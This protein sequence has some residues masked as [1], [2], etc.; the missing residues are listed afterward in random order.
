MSGPEILFNTWTEEEKEEALKKMIEISS[1]GGHNAEMCIALGLKS[2]DTFYR[3]KREI[4]EF[5]AMCDEAR[6]YGKSFY[7]NLLLR[8]AAGLVPNFNATATMGIVNNKFAEDYKRNADGSSNTPSIGT[9][10]IVNLNSDELQYK[11]AQK[12]EVLKRYGEIY[13]VLPEPSKEE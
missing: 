2:E 7:D 9:V 5:K 10:N 8:G 6:L 12:L 3:W 11:I 4:P 13:D 1:R